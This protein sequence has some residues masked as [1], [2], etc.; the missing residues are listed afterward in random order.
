MSF[1]SHQKKIK[2]RVKIKNHEREVLAFFLSLRN[3]KIRLLLRNVVI[4]CYVIRY[5]SVSLKHLFAV[6]FFF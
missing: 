4:I 5:K 6:S 3:A 1:N 2:N